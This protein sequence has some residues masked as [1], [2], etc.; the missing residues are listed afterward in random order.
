MHKPVL[1]EDIPVLRIHPAVHRAHQAVIQVP[2]MIIPLTNSSGNNDNNG[3]SLFEFI[4]ILLIVLYIAW[5]DN[6]KQ[7]QA[8]ISQ[9]AEKRFDE[10]QLI[11]FKQHD[12]NF[13]RILFL[14]FVHLLYVKYYLSHLI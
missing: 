13:S 12:V 10:S 7:P 1:V 9:S 3:V 2:R 6:K 5:L 14:D 8:V 11:N 4:V